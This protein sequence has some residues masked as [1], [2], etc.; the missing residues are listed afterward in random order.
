VNNLTFILA[1]ILSLLGIFVQAIFGI[2][3]ALAQLSFLVLSIIIYLAL[4]KLDAY[5]L[6][7]LTPLL[8]G[9]GILL[10]TLLFLV[11]DPIRG[12]KRWF[13][14]F[15]FNFQPAVIFLPFFILYLTLK[16]Y[17]NKKRQFKDLLQYLGL[18]LIPFF[19][20]FKQPDLGTAT[21]L[22]FSLTAVT[23]SAGFL[24]TYYVKLLVLMAPLLAVLSRFLKTYQL[25]RIISF[26]N[27]QYD[28]SGINYNSLQSAIA[29]GSGFIFGKG[30]YRASQSK[31]HFLPEAHTDF[32][33][34][35]FIEA[36]GFLGGTLV[37]GL[38]FYL[39]FSLLKE[40]SQ[41]RHGELYRNYI[42]GVTAFFFIQT[43]FN[44]GMN[45]RLLPVVGVPLPFISYGGS[46][47]LSNFILLSLGAKLK[48]LG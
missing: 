23:F 16:L 10:L 19:L 42:F 2:D 46:G 24:W 3:Y 37:L 30:F 6:L 14:L 15:G 45:L 18:I 29:I 21:V 41:N 39:L 44:V 38:L 13:V 20:I 27:P 43:V 28:P 33:F 36:F 34:A 12:A 8:S 7:K 1:I 48:E 25:E 5:L 11:G 4:S 26:I 31:L 17:E 40:W 35:T 22:F 47:L 9:L 32:A